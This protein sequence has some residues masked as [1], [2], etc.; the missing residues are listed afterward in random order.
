MG[1]TEERT[2][3]VRERILNRRA[4]AQEDQGAVGGLTWTTPSQAQRSDRKQNT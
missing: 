1:G 4:I 3:G 2:A